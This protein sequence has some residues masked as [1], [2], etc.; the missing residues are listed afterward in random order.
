MW[1][2]LATMVALSGPSWGC[3]VIT[4]YTDRLIPERFGAVN[5]GPISLIRPKYRDDKGLHEHEAVHFRQWAT[6][7]A[8][9]P[10]TAFIAFSSKVEMVQPYLLAILLAPSLFHGVLYKL[11][12]KYRQACEV[13]AYKEQLEYYDDDRTELF[14]GYIASKYG[15]DV[16]HTQAVK[17]LKEQ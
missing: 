14:A 3:N 5:V 1:K 13:S 17:F 12:S 8:I 11:I 15:L 7:A 6:L 10:L 4:F 2:V 9:G 16:T